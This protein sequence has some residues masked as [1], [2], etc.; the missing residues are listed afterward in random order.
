MFW[1]VFEQKIK[2]NIIYIQNKLQSTDSLAVDLLD[3][4]IA[5]SNLI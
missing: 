2:F 5:P 3:N 1:A 4:N